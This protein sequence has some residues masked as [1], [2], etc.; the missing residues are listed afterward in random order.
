MLRLVRFLL[1]Y[2]TFSVNG[3][4]LERFINL[5]AVRGISLFNI[6]RGENSF[7]CS[8]L[9]TEYRA[10]VGIA[11]ITRVE[12]EVKEESGLP[13][14]L[15]KYRKRYGLFL[16]IIIFFLIQIFLS[17]FVWDVSV[18]GN[19]S[20][21]EEEVLRLVENIGVKNGVL[22]RYIDPNMVEN[23]ILD[24]I[25]G[26]S[27]ASVNLIGSK[28]QIEIKEKVEAPEIVKDESPC[29]I[30][31]NSDAQ[32]V[33]LE[34]YKG[35]PEVKI[36]D[37]V[38]KGQILVNGVLENAFG[39]SEICHAEA[40][41]FAKLKKVIREEIDI[42]CIDEIKTNKKVKRS[43]LKFF[44]RNV[45]L[46]LVP[47]PKGNF[48]CEF[49][50]KDFY[51]FGT[52]LPL[53]ISSEVWY[54]YDKKRTWLGKEEAKKRAD[55]N[56]RRRENL[57]LEGVQVLKYEDCEKLSNDKFVLTRTYECIK[58]IAEKDPIVIS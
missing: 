18:L 38:T 39:E 23:Y 49:R 25:P 58:N 22:K 24:E 55:A 36:G 1:G 14:I 8:S 43:S 45:P 6:E 32:I 48:K 20:I 26:I 4:F 44:T 33:R 54:K 19:K 47:V 16:G 56:I 21:S 31:A 10:L 28:V 3:K 37:A 9:A 13:V 2:V 11:K 27:W 12:I 30:K 17:F 41:I 53:K 5:S 15:R 34:V 29:N 46:T 42:D 50:S 52:R 40:K 7:S 35:N 57:E 51:L